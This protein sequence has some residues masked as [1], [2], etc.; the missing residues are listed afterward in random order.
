MLSGQAQCIPGNTSQKRDSRPTASDD[1][2]H[3][4]SWL[5]TIFLFKGTRGPTLYPSGLATWPALFNEVYF[6]GTSWMYTRYLSERPWSIW[7]LSLDLRS[8]NTATGAAM[9]CEWEISIYACVSLRWGVVR[10]C[11]TIESVLSD[12]RVVKAWQGR[13]ERRGSI[14]RK[15][16]NICNTS[17]RGSYQL[18]HSSPLVPILNKMWQ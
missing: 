14:W 8:A 17:S 3:R 7:P 13:T 4:C 11:R 9:Q 2:L 6:T 1:A 12:N 18:T 16:R 15:R 5:F 10:Y